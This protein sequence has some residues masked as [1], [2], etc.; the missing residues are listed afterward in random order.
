MKYYLILYHVLFSVNCCTLFFVYLC[1]LFIFFE[2]INKYTCQKMMNHTLLPFSTFQVTSFLRKHLR[3]PQFQQ[4]A[5]MPICVYLP[6]WKSSLIKK[7]K[8]LICVQIICINRSHYLW[9]YDIISRWKLSPFE[10]QLRWHKTNE[11]S[12]RLI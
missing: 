7:S 4:R 1:I 8:H 11:A 6:S 12:E 9:H 3:W 10:H 2:L 5:S